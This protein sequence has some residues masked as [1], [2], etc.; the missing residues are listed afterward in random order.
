MKTLIERE[1]LLAA[2]KKSGLRDKADIQELVYSA[3]VVKLPQLECEGYIMFQGKM[4]INPPHPQFKPYE[5]EGVWLYKPDMQCWYC[6]GHS[7][8]ASICRRVK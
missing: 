1:P 4:I 3:P 2:L 7:F 5:L 8:P 6:N